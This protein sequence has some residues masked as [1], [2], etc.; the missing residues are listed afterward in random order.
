MKNN[1]DVNKTPVIA[2]WETTQAC[3]VACLDYGNWTQ[4][5]ADPLELST[6]E[7]QKMIDE[8][9]E[10]CPP[11]FVLTGA[12]PLK[13]PDIY[14]LI[15]YASSQHLHPFL[16]LPATPLLTRDAIADLKHAHL[17]RLV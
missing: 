16:E 12:D 4:P 17:S 8:V 1:F 14:Q 11:I 2:V 15:R 6:L 3:D 13:R 7:A 9:A 10:L 5:D